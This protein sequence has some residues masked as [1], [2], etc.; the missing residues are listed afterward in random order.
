VTSQD[1][2]PTAEQLADAGSPP[3]A[4]APAPADAASAPAAPAA[5]NTA[6]A[7]PAPGPASADTATANAPPAAAAPSQLQAH[8]DI[9]STLEASGQFTILDR[10]LAQTNL[11][12]VL[13]SS[14][15]LTLIAPTDAAFNS[16]P[17]GQLADLMKPENAQKL[18]SL[19]TYHV[20]NAAVPLTKIEGSRGPVQTVNGAKVVI[21]GSANPIKFNDAD[22]TATA[23]T[24]NG[25]IYVVDK[26][27]SPDRLAAEAATPASPGT[28]TASAQM[29][30]AQ[31]ASSPAA[32]AQ[33]TAN[34][35]NAPS[36]SNSGTPV[37]AT[38][39][40][41]PSGGGQA[42][43]GSAVSSAPVP[44]T[45]ENRAKFGGPMSRSGKATQASGN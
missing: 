30:A 31:P 24:S 25:S 8:G 22:V 4:S 39:P 37:S 2:E 10:A 3:A 40:A 7:P 5:T 16:L 27:L 11:T 28:P 14:G 20:I 9:A 18:Q 33:P 13:K 42:A 19:L 29:A 12:S 15:P 35:V 44:D 45:P 43:S 21:D 17:P 38:T 34:A 32:P 36:A 26:V 41:T 1:V 6:P 23:S